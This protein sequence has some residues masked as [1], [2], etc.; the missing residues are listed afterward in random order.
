MTHS[1]AITQKGAKHNPFICVQ[2]HA[3]AN[4]HFCCTR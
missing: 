1:R 2:N 3:Y 4:A